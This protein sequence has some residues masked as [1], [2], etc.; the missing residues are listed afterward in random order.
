MDKQHGATKS[1]RNLVQS[2]TVMTEGVHFEF[3]IGAWIFV[4]I[5][6]NH[7]EHVF[8][9]ITE[10]LRVA[11]GQSQQQTRHARSHGDQRILSI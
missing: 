6:S 11:I 8:T 10:V 5:A 7:F 1:N 9:Y 3:T 2:G 4:P